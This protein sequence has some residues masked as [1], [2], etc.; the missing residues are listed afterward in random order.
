M[1]NLDTLGKVLTWMSRYAGGAVPSVTDDAYLQW[2]GWISE[3][4]E[5]AAER[6]FWSRLLTKADLSITAAETV[7]LP[8]DFHKRNGIYALFV[9]G[10]DWN[11]ANNSDAQTLFVNKNATGDWVLTF[12]GFTPTEA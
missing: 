5:D 2:V 6:G 11:E 12:K 9:D 7:T 1:Q 4:Q 10:I 3:A 8:D